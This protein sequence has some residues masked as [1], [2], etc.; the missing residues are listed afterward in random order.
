MIRALLIAGACLAACP[1]L[2]ADNQG[3]AAPKGWGLASCQQFLDQAKESEENVIRI[4]S[5]LEGYISAANVYSE[6]T[7]DLAPW[8][9]PVYLLNIIGR[10]CQ[11][12][13]EERFIRVVHAYVQYLAQGRLKERDDVLIATSGENRRPVYKSVLIDV[14]E[15]LGITA[16]GVFGPGT[17]SAL[18]EYQKA[19]NLPQTGLPDSLTIERL[20]IASQQQPQPQ[21]LRPLSPTEPPA[22]A[23]PPEQQ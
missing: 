12:A 5:W 10:N 4:G 18:E 23:E 1:A 2:A 9:D 22:A 17:K 7:Y 15:A 20:L 14:Q 8:Q 19:N 16:D 13:P 11:N 3:R 21:P 6:D